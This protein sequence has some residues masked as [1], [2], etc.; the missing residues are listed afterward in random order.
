MVTQSERQKSGTVVPQCVF[1][2]GNTENPL[3]IDVSGRFGS[4]I[5]CLRV[6]GYAYTCV[7]RGNF[8]VR[9]SF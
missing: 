7:A 4:R 3:G 8:W 2:S 5:A 1:H 6:C 9:F